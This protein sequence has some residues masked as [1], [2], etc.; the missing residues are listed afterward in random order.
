MGGLPGA[1]KDRPVSTPRFEVLT[2][3][4]R[5]Q[6]DL[7]ELDDMLDRLS[8]GRVRLTEAD[9]GSDQFAIVLAEGKLTEDAATGI[10]RMWWAAESGGR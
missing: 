7:T 10:Y 4:H 5:E 1:R 2:W 3:D 9:T 8:G 6:P